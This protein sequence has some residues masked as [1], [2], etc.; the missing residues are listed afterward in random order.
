MSVVRYFDM[1]D[2]AAVMACSMLMHALVIVCVHSFKSSHR[3][4]MQELERAQIDYRIKE[5]R[6]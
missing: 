4:A 5:G 2:W 6:W 3:S 1:I